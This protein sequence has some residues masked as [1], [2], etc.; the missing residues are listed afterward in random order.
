LPDFFGT[1]YQIRNKMYQ[2]NTKCTKWT[3][4]VPN[5]HK[6]SQMFIKY[7]KLFSN[8]RP[9]KIYPNWDFWSENK[10]SGNPGEGEAQGVAA[11]PPSPKKTPVPRET[12]TMT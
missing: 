8:L 9:Y 5:G 7:S 12:V 1:L 2:M 11:R 10:L 4:N 6:I 3:Q